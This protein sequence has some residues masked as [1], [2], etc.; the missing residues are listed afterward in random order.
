VF[1]MANLNKVMLIG[2]LTRDPEVRMFSNGGKVAKF[3][4]AV[5]NRR[6]NQQTGQWE[7]EPVFL[8][9]E[10][11]N[12]GEFGK[13]ADLVEQYL[14]KGSQVFIEG[15]LKFD[16]WT[17]QEGQKRTAI[18]VVLDNMQFLEPRAD[19]GTGGQPRTYPPR[20]K[21]APGAP[22]PSDFD[23][24]SDPGERPMDPPPPGAGEENIPF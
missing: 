21:D 3:G 18:K 14:H 19:G 16:Q 20:Q 17:S 22:P 12:R 1:I 15:H 9:V 23:P 11:F 2:R 24:G 4:F 8:E 5:N 6:K 10:A 13:T 7:D